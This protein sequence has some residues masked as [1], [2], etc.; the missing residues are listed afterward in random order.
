M[1]SNE[2]FTSYSFKGSLILVS[3]AAAQICSTIIIQYLIGNELDAQMIGVFIVCAIL[4]LPGG[5]YLGRAISTQLIT[6]PYFEMEE[7]SEKETLATTEK[8]LKDLTE[9]LAEKT[10][11]FTKS[12]NILENFSSQIKIY[13]IVG[14]VCFLVGIGS[15]FLLVNLSRLF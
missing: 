3:F 2:K 13:A 4:I 15:V 11:V 8:I 10:L 5:F 9:E 14:L 1:S 7:S 12:T 6:T